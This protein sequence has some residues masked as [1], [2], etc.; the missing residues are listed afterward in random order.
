MQA[1]TELSRHFHEYL[2]IAEGAKGAVEWISEEASEA[3]ERHRQFPAVT[4][5]P[6]VTPVLRLTGQNSITQG[7]AAQIQDAHQNFVS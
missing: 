3:R 2:K 5:L 7:Q 6:A 4:Q 1:L